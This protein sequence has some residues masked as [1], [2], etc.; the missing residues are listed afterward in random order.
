MCTVINFEILLF[1]YKS[2]AI[3]PKSNKPMI[4]WND[5]W[6]VEYL[7]SAPFW[8]ILNLKI[9]V[10]LSMSSVVR[11]EGSRLFSLRTPTGWQAHYYRT[12]YWWIIFLMHFNFVGYVAINDATQYFVSEPLEDHD[13]GAAAIYCPEIVEIFHL[14]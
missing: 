11:S 14:V 13:V 12:F 4:W 5:K 9:I 3:C 2:W 10:Y 6:Y 1:F 7:M 8:M